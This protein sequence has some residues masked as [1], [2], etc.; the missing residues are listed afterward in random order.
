[1]EVTLNMSPVWIDMY[2][3]ETRCGGSGTQWSGVYM[4]KDSFSCSSVTML[5]YVDG[6]TS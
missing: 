2:E 1:M 6:E 3:R 5:L 4:R